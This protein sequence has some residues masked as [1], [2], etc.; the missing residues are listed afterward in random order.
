MDCRR[1]KY[2]CQYTIWLMTAYNSSS[3]KNLYSG[4]HMFLH[5][6][7]HMFTQTNIFMEFK[8]TINLKNEY[9]FRYPLH[10]KAEM[11]F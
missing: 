10:L 3:K 8:S 9:I 4:L 7:G 2:G 5:L 6:H 11:N 1:P